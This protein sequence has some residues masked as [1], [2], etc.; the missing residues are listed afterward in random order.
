MPRALRSPSR[1]RGSLRAQASE[2]SVIVIGAGYGG[3][4]LARALQIAGVCVIVLEQDALCEGIVS[5]EL[6]VP[7]A[8]RVLAVLGLGAHWKALA[9][10]T[11]PYCLPFDALRNE[12]AAS[13]QPGTL[14]CG[15]RVISVEEGA[16]G[17]LSAAVEHGACV[18]ADV[19]VIASGMASPSISPSAIHRTALVGDARWASARW[20]DLGATRIRYGADMAM[21]EG[22]ELGERLQR[23][24][25]A[26]GVGTVDSLGMYAASRRWPSGKGCS[27][28]TTDPQA[29]WHAFLKVLAA[30]LGAALASVVVASYTTPLRMH[31]VH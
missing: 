31:E 17:R 30:V 22:L 3:L 28:R 12:L 8:E 7:S 18:A 21:T 25:A 11:Q 29:S 19:I 4:V 1:V 23:V 13:L 26:I 2:L 27:I 20:W 16:D 15:R 14:L 5:G 9:R 24:H 10:A 6:R